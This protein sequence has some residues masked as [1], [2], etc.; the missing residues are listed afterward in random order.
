LDQV[1]G[2]P[3]DDAT[4]IGPLTHPDTPTILAERVMMSLE[5]G[6]EVIVGGTT[7][8]DD[9][10]FGRFFAPTLLAGMDED[11]EISKEESFG[12]IV[13]VTKVKSDAE[14]IVRMNTNK[15]GLTN[16]IYTASWDRAHYM[17]KRLQSGTV[18]M[19]KCDWVDPE[20]AWVGYK[21]SGKG[22]SLSPLVFNH[23]TRPKA[24]NFVC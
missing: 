17:A 7:M 21:S 15:Y 16:A 1:L 11:M 5:S 2:D 22:V 18:F 4:T 23:V 3:L 9:A 8:Q 19:N 10:G 12:P 24:F 14:A 13:A 20:L 6:G